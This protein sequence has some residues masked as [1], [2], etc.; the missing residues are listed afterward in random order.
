MEHPKTEGP[1]PTGKPEQGVTLTGALLPWKDGQPVLMQ[2]PGAPFNYLPCFHDVGE[3]QSFLEEWSIEYDSIKQIDNGDEFLESLLP[4]F[5]SDHLKVI[6]DP[7]TTDEGR[8]RF[9][10]LQPPLPN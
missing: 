3:A 4:Y 10:E 8:V 9:L 5:L 6:M 2:M 1:K 7:W